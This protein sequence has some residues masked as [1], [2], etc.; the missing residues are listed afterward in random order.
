MDQLSMRPWLSRSSTPVIPSEGVRA[1]SR[2][3]PIAPKP[4]VPCDSESSSIINFQNISVCPVTSA[5]T[6]VASLVPKH[7]SIKKGRKRRNKNS[8]TH[9]PALKRLAMLSSSSA[10]ERREDLSGFRRGRAAD[11]FSMIFQQ[12]AEFMERAAASASLSVL[13]PLDS[14]SLSVLPPLDRK[15]KT[16]QNDKFFSA[17]DTFNVD[18]RSDALGS[19]VLNMG[20]SLKH[21]AS[22]EI[23]FLKALQTSRFDEEEC[24]ERKDDVRRKS[25]ALS[26][27]PIHIEPSL[28]SSNI[29]Q[30]CTSIACVER[31]YGAC[32]EPVM[33]IDDVTMRILWANFGYWE[34]CK[35]TVNAD[36]LWEPSRFAQFQVRLEGQSKF[37]P[38]TLWRLSGKSAMNAHG[39]EF[40]RSPLLRTNALRNDKVLS[41]LL[42]SSEQHSCC[43]N[44]L[45]RTDIGCSRIIVPE[46]RRPVCSTISVESI[47][48]ISNAK[49]ELKYSSEH[50]ESQLEESNLPGLIADVLNVVRGVN[51]AYKAMVGQPECPWL[52]STVHSC[53]PTI[54]GAVLLSSNVDIPTSASSFSGR[55]NVQWTRRNSG[56]R[57]SMTLPCDV[58]AFEADDSGRMLAWQFDIHAGLGLTCPA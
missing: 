4:P 50:V 36:M 25:I 46:P 40:H 24:E 35:G 12:D 1:L 58:T 18:D 13:P 44:V 6:H 3:R 38:A 55:V 26:F 22:C 17:G 41:D 27:S 19:C 33:L 52:M 15:G 37:I 2:Y 16:I 11:S 56:Q 29:N 57:T 8:Q 31:I 39:C 32:L 49:D 53:S 5:L 23:Q 54:A 42:Y 51:T 7:Q 30:P 45:G 47:T 48:G 10:R 21:N 34:A 28:I 9:T 14:A 20:T 43:N